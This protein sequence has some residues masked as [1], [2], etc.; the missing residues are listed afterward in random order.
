M[1]AKPGTWSCGRTVDELS[2]PRMLAIFSRRAGRAGARL[3]AHFAER[4]ALLQWAAFDPR[5]LAQR[6]LRGLFSH[7]VDPRGLAP[8]AF[9]LYAAARTAGARLS[10]RVRRHL[11][12]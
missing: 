7:P 8:G 4:V 5:A 9:E 3:A 6:L 1:A 12:A 2:P 11:P 10:M